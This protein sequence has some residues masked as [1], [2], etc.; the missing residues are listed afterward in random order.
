MIKN[1]FTFIIALIIC[2]I[3]FNCSNDLSGGSSTVESG[4]ISICVIDTL[5]KLVENAIVELY[6]EKF[7]SINSL[8]NVISTKTNSNGYA[9]FDSIPNGIYS[10][11]AKKD[12]L[13]FIVYPVNVNSSPQLS[14]DTLTVNKPG[15]LFI[16]NA[17]NIKALFFNGL[18]FVGD[19][20][21]ILSRVVFDKIP[22]GSYPPLVCMSKSDEKHE[23]ENID[24]KPNQELILYSDSLILVGSIYYDVP[25][26][27]FNDRVLCVDYSDDIFLCGTENNSV[28]NTTFT[29]GYEQMPF[30][31]SIWL[32]D[33]IQKI[34]VGPVQNYGDSSFLLIQTSSGTIWRHKNL[35]MNLGWHTLTEVSG[36]KSNDIY[37]DNDYFCWVAYDT[38]VFYFEL[39]GKEW[40]RISNSSNVSAI[41]GTGLQVMYFASEQ[42]KLIELNSI[43]TVTY[44]VEDEDGVVHKINDLIT[45]SDGD[46]YIASDLGLLRKNDNSF[47]TVFKSDVA[48]LKLLYFD[49]Y[50]CGIEGE[51]TFFIINN[52]NDVIRIHA[53]DDI[54]EFKDLSYRNYLG[55]N[56][57]FI[58]SADKGITILNLN[59]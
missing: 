54:T 37:I 4:Y 17:F 8:E 24:I 1:R 26:R 48:V 56:K 42:S 23:N 28:W 45:T 10:I 53:P 27:P 59:K 39:N 3:N 35:F 15:N 11:I 29:L 2:S 50:I 55:D 33:T 44:I 36:Q 19:F 46:L 14:S 40:K 43:D 22:C 51:N 18:P 58:A 38:S 31:S 6:D 21:S 30:A 9:F 32:M 25:F 13:S 16:E 49:N 7:P 34:S 5:G 41:A 20:D 52:N 47:Q 57:I 12:S